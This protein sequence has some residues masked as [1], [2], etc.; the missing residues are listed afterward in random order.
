VGRCVPSQCTTNADCTNG[1]ACTAVFGWDCSYNV[2]VSGFECQGTGDACGGPGDCEGENAACLAPS[3]SGTE[4][5]TCDVPRFDCGRPFVVEGKARMAETRTAEWSRTKLA[6]D[7]PDDA[8]VRA[9][10]AR[11]W[12]HIGVMEHASIAAFARFSLQLLS[13][14]APA[15]LVEQSNQA[16]ADELSHAELAFALASAYEGNDVAPGPLSM[17]GALAGASLHDV[18]ELV[19]IEG[20]VGETIAALEAREGAAHASDPAI[21][22]ALERVADDETR[23][24]ALAW[25]A[26]RWGLAQGDGSTFER[27]EQAF[28]R[29]LASQPVE[30]QPELDD[31][32][33]HG[34]LSSTLRAELRE[35]ARAVL[36]SGLSSLRAQRQRRERAA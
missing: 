35:Q 25:R 11:H 4:S 8:N 26:L 15:Q 12:T 1:A 18:L 7:L 5:R 27:V 28:E 22:T 33:R 36:R 17:L 13:L 30:P 14:G 20:C 16:L 2:I 10:L 21:R 6:F 9:R 34:V 32:T 23:H 19:V 24:A 3:Y 29:G 31:L